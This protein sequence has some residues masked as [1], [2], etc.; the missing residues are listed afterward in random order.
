LEDITPPDVVLLGSEWPTRALLRA[1]LLEEGHDVVATDA[2]PIPGQY[3]RPGMKPRAVIIDLH[4]L[5]EPRRVLAEL[6]VLI[7][8]DR[9]LVLTALGTLASDDIRGL[10]FHVVARP[11]SI[12]E[13]VAVATGLLRAT[14]GS[15]DSPIAR[16]PRQRG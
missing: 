13:I 7:K 16:Q 2:W 9:V 14:P 4:G 15:A 12:G 3:L 10:G 11:A 1:Q 5:T 6:R 8:P